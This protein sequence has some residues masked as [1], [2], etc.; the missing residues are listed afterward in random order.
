MADTSVANEGVADRNIA[1]DGVGCEQGQ[2]P[3]DVEGIG[4]RDEGVDEF[5][6]G[7]GYLR[8]H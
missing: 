3:F 6:H 2:C 1:N 5:L 4:G 8:N 7:A